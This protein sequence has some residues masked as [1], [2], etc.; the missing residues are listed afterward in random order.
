MNKN[1][2]RAGMIDWCDANFFFHCT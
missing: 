2:W 1:I